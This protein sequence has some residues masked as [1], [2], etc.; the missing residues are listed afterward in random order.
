MKKALKKRKNQC[1]EELCAFENMSVLDSDEESLNVS[2]SEEGEFWKRVSD[3]N[4]NIHLKHSSKTLKQQSETFF[5]LADCINANYNYESLCSCLVSQSNSN[6]NKNNSNF[7]SSTQEDLSTNIV[8]ESISYMK[9]PL[10]KTN[11]KQLL[12]KVNFVLP[13]GT[14]KFWLTVR[15]KHLMKTYLTSDQCLVNLCW[16]HVK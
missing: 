4:F 16:C 9:G 13:Q 10:N 6:F 5:N 12:H 15:K 8:T 1:V 14:F 3:E 11:I 7:N 2:S